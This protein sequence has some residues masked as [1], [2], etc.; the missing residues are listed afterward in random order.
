MR[1]SFTHENLIVLVDIKYFDK[2]E[3]VELVQ[4]WENEPSRNLEEGIV[5][6][7]RMTIEDRVNEI[8]WSALTQSYEVGIGK[9]VLGEVVNYYFIDFRALQV[10]YIKVIG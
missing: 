1:L 10:A 2:L 7:S 5:C 9:A 3:F 8:Y 6:Q 4:V